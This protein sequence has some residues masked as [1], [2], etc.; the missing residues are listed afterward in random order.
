MKHPLIAVLALLSLVLPIGYAA[1]QSAPLTYR[2]WSVTCNN[3]KTCMAYSVSSRS[4]GG[5]VSRPRG[6]SDDVQAGWMTI[7]RAAGPTSTPRILL[8]R[9]DLSSNSIPSD[10]EIRLLDTSGRLVER[11]IFAATM[12][13]TGAIEIAPS[14]NASFISVARGASHAVLVVGP[15]K[16]KVFFVSLS[17]LV[18]SG[19]A[20]DAHQGRT[21]TT[22]ALIDIGRRSASSVPAA[23]AR[24]ILTA[25]SFT[26]RAG[27][28]PPAAVMALRTAA[29]DDAER[30]DAGGTNIEAFNLDRGRILWSVPCGAGAYNMW[31]QLYIQAPRTGIVMAHFTG[32][33]VGDS[34]EAI[35][36]VNASIN[37]AKGMI[38]AF[39]KGRGLGDC[40]SAE[41][42]V[43]TGTDFALAELS[44][45][46]PCGG[47]IS[48]FWPSVFTSSVV[49]R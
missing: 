28:R 16:R 37:P 8:S 31:N 14:L 2:D 24:P 11:G 43:W 40:G 45:M 35:G 46:V 36:I 42:Y 44:E 39:D 47:I 5:L 22:N 10:A 25:Q 19:R 3:I 48:D 12:G 29:C 27:V 7:E 30:L 20:I 26:K 15:V 21:G 41:T 6:L 49:T 1:A 33:P 4:E 13:S 23:A 9:P 32:K 34:E 18:A 17:G 38:T